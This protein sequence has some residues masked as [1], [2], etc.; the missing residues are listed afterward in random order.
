MAYVIFRNQLQAGLSLTLNSADT[1]FVLRFALNRV[2]EVRIEA[3][4]YG[5]DLTHW[6]ALE[7]YL[8][9]I[10]STHAVAVV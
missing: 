9:T 2:R 3:R 6:E 4:L 7:V 10:N 1:D 5:V 8:A